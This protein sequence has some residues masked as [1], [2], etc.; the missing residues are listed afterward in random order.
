MENVETEPMNAWLNEYTKPNVR[1][2]NQSAFKVYLAWVKKT[3][4]KLVTEFDQA[5]TKNQVLQFQNYL[6][7]DFISPHTKQKLKANSV[8]SILTAVRAFYSSQC[9]EIHGLKNKIVNAE[10]A[11][12]E[13]V[14][15]LQ[16]L[17]AM[18]AI[19][20]SRNKAIL[21]T[22]TSLGWETNAF[23]GLE[24][25]FVE[26]LVKRA[27]SQNMEFITFDWQ[28]SKEGTPQFGILNPLAL[29][30]LEQYIA[31]VNK[32]NPTQT[33]LF[34]INEQSLNNVIKKLVEDANITTVGTVRFHLIR[35]FVMDSLSD[36]GMNE[37]QICIIVGKSV[38]SDKLTYLR[39]LK[40]SAF[41]KYKKAY[42]T[43]FS[44]S[45]NAANG[46]AIYNELVDLVVKHV[47]SQERLI[48]YM[49]QNGMLKTLPKDL[50]EQLN[51]VV[52]F[53]KAMQKQNGKKSE[54]EKQEEPQETDDK[55][56]V[57]IT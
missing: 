54:S 35:K 15:E 37:F 29:S 42:G 48:E 55:Q 6:V 38:P 28:R 57:P 50:T 36:C 14:F 46:K 41:E 31:K 27:K 16:D 4:Q 33:K 30:T 49:K 1:S 44:L 22:A 26:N 8:R 39:K 18:F 47:K 9:A 24:K 10:M 3:P 7:N 52:E 51:S 2:Q 13:H 21:A 25:E 34:D 32:D 5:Q 17:K 56:K 23:L 19:A 45:Q 43:H 11:K 40:Q 53:A 12:G 20:D